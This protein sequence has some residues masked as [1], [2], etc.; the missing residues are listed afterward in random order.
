M[1]SVWHIND[2]LDRVIVRASEDLHALD[3]KQ[4]FITGGT[5]FIGG[6]LLEV[7]RR[8]KNV[9]IRVDAHILTRDQMQFAEKSPH[10]AEFPDFNFYAGDITTFHLPNLKPDFIFHAATAASA[11]LNEDDPFQM[12][13]T[14]LFGTRHLLDCAAEWK[15]SRMLLLSSGAVYG[16]QPFGMEKIPE[17]WGGAPDCTDPVN[18]YAEAKRGAELL[19]AIA[20]RK[21]GL[22]V[23][24]ARIFAVL[25]PMLELN[26]HFAAGNFL[27]DAMARRSVTVNGDGS[28]VR[29]YVYPTDLMVMLLALLVRGTAG[30]AYNVGSTEAV[31]IGQLA[32]MI[33]SIVGTGDFKILG[34]HDKGWNP[35][36]YVPDTSAI[37]SDFEID[38]EVGL[39]QAIRNTASYNG[40][41][42]R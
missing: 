15:S 34:S 11:K 7:L 5:G 18:A 25:G 40:W 30:R 23:S 41:R 3:G 42:A 33:S 19:S 17:G 37:H 8:A 22:S 32:E 13:D 21:R 36:R 6:W 24:I 12:F 38:I 9:G 1:T 14:A 29:S 16:R 4:I 35:G 26:A 2:D 20:A 10:L 39:E 27:S 31:S 28:A